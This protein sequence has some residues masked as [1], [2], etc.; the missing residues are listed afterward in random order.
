VENPGLSKAGPRDKRDVNLPINQQTNNNGALGE[1]PLSIPVLTI[2]HG[3]YESDFVDY[4][5][6]NPGFLAPGQPK[7]ISN[8]SY[9]TLKYEKKEENSRFPA[10][11]QFQLKNPPQISWNR[12]VGAKEYLV[13]VASDVKFQNILTRQRVVKNSWIWKN[14]EI[15]F[16]YWRVQAFGSHGQAGKVSSPETLVTRLSPPVFLQ[17]LKDYAVE[18]EKAPMALSWT[19][20]FKAESYRLVVSEFDEYSERESPIQSEIVSDPKVMAEP[21]GV[22]VYF[23]RVAA[24]DGEGRDLSSLSAPLKVNVSFEAPVILS[25]KDNTYLISMN[26]NEGNESMVVFQWE[27]KNSE[28]K[29]QLQLSKDKEFTEIIYDKKIS[30]TR[31]LVKNE[32]PLSAYYWRVRAWERNTFSQWSVTHRFNVHY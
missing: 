20:I 30:E 3:P 31:H 5:N 11:H 6:K 15:G 25:P 27:A 19:P 26:A 21:P 2:P 18:T 7:L 17:E 16:F 8:K 32:F 23:F 1:T 10:S 12:V 14:P 9:F 29:Y 4:L 24:V 22:G 28:S 13:E